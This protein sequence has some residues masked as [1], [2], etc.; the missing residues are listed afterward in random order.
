MA[1]GIIRWPT[2]GGN[3]TFDKVYDKYHKEQ[4]TYGFFTIQ[5]GKSSGFKSYITNLIIRSNSLE[6]R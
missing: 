6:F 1:G 2:V 3:L 4:L 5:G